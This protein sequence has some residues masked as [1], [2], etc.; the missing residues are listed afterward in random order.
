MKTWTKNSYLLMFQFSRRV[1]NCGN[2]TFVLRANI[3]PIA[4][5]AAEI[6]AFHLLELAEISSGKVRDGSFG[7]EL[8][9]TPRPAFFSASCGE[10]GNLLAH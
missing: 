1:T 2:S 7:L 8:K 10:G 5:K 3:P 6:P 4:Q 9:N